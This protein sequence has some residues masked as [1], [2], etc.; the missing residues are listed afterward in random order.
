VVG[1]AAGGTGDF[2]A[3]VVGNKLGEKF[4]RTV[5]AENRAG[6]SGPVGGQ[7]V[8]NAVPDGYTILC[9]QTQEIAIN[10]YFL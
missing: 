3:R 10:P 7:F 4:G 6:A 9:G 5:V 1:Y 8:A 2:I